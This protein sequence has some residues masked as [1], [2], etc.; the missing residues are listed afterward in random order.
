[1]YFCQLRRGLKFTAGNNYPGGV[2][3]APTMGARVEMM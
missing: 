3:V 1:M 2:Y